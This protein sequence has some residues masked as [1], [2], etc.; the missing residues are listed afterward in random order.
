MGRITVYNNS[1]VSIEIPPKS[2]LQRV[3]SAAVATARAMIRDEP[4][5]IRLGDMS[6]PDRFHI[7]TSRI[8]LKARGRPAPTISNATTL[9]R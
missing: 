2:A 8:V 4:R 5:Y 6:P 3:N 7:L 9:P 1:L